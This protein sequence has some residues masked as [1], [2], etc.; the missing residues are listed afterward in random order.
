[1]AK[2]YSVCIEDGA[3][4][5]HGP[6]PDADAQKNAIRVMRYEGKQAFYLDLRHNGPSMGRVYKVDGGKEL[7]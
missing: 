6:Y 4:V 5:V 7:A 1:M 2:F 3:P